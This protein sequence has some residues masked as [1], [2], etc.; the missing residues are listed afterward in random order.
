MSLMGDRAAYGVAG[1]ISHRWAERPQSVQGWIA[2]VEEWCPDQL[3]EGPLS[4]P[5]GQWCHVYLAT[6]DALIGGVL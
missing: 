4:R 3:P 1:V 5:G 2:L 6:L